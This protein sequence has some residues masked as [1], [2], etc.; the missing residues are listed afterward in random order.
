MEKNF[1]TFMLTYPL[2]VV[3]SYQRFQVKNKF[4]IFRADWQLKMILNKIKKNIKECFNVFQ[5]EPWLGKKKRFTFCMC[6]VKQ[7]KKNVIVI[8]CPLQK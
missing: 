4:S 7:Q 5:L 2:N 8:R 3:Y 6:V 1:S